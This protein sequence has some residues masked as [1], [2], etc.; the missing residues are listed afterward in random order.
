MLAFCERKTTEDTERL[1][2]SGTPGLQR[3]NG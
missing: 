2:S 1:P 3:A